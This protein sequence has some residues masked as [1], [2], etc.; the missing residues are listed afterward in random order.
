MA[1]TL[2]LLVVAGAAFFTGS[3]PTHVLAQSSGEVG[4][5]TSS[6]RGDPSTSAAAPPMRPPLASPIA[7]AGANAAPSPAAALGI[8]DGGM[9]PPALTP[10][11][12]LTATAGLIAFHIGLFTLVGRERKSPYIINSVFPIFLICLVV[13][14]LALLSVLLPSW[15][16]QLLLKGS[17]GLLVL[18]FLFSAIR[19]YRIAVRSVYFVDS[20]SLKHL[21]LVRDWRRRKSLKSSRRNY[22]HNTIPIPDDL[23]ADI[24]EILSAANAETFEDRKELDPKALALAVQHQGQ[25]NKLL[26]QLAEAFLRKD[27]SVQYLTASRHPIEFVGFLKRHLEDR[28]LTWSNYTRRI[29]VIDAYSPHFAFLDSI[30]PKKDRELESLDV[31]CVVSRMTYA[32]MHTASSHAFNVIQ[33][34]V[35]EKDRRPTLVIYEDAYALTDLESPEQYRIFVRHVMPSE[36]MWDGMFTVFLESAMLDA[37]WRMLQGYASMRLDLRQRS[38]IPDKGGASPPDKAIPDH[39][40]PEVVA[41]AA[42][43]AE[44]NGLVKDVKP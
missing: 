24:V 16:E 44:L 17:A 30:Y 22:A 9:P 29:V 2:A 21:P 34:Q 36:R 31:E 19:V 23:K 42:S 38:V 14:A 5:S 37:D 1:V 20:I 12:L 8:V 10:W 27:F 35:A 7:A 41:M 11:A 3:I 26:A 18:T 39:P 28:N 32:G 33:K 4:T 13:A 43:A 6:P 15:L 40:R 25:G